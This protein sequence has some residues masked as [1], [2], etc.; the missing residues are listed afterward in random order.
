MILVLTGVSGSGKTTIGHLLSRKLAWPFYDA[1]GFHP[2]ENIGKM[3]AG[4]PLD[5]E[6]RG[7]W[8]ENLTGKMQEE[9]AAGRDAIFACSA[10]KKSYRR[11]LREVGPEVRLVFL[12]GE[13]SLVERRVGERKGH[14]MKRGMVAGQFASLEEPESALAVDASP[15]PDVVAEAILG[16]L[17]V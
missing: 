11:I 9:I 1:D 7:P 2:E 6:D 16:R 8:L 4:I 14:F 5:D 10:L 12:K 13:P 15:P 17:G 3:S